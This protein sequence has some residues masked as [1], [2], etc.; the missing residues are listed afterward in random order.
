MPWFFL[1]LPRGMN[2]G[3][4]NSFIER[5]IPRQKGSRVVNQVQLGHVVFEE[6]FQM[7][8]FGVLVCTS[9]HI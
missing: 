6:S 1:A 5:D 7:R 8:V 4:V 3:L 2:K 9:L